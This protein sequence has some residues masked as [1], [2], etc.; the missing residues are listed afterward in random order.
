MQKMYK[1]PVQAVARQIPHNDPLLI[2]I[3]VHHNW[4]KPLSRHQNDPDYHQRGSPHFKVAIE[5]S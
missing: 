4:N 2:E 1:I 5:V 3:L